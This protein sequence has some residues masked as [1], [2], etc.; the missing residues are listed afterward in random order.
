MLGFTRT[1]T[2]YRYHHVGSLLN[3]RL[4]SPRHGISFNR[5][6]LGFTLIETRS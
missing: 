5:Q 6:A 3:P 2:Q 4:V 1:K